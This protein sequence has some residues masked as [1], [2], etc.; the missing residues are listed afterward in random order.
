MLTQNP[1]SNGSKSSQGKIM[2]RWFVALSTLPLL[3][4]VT[5]FGLVPQGDFDLTST[6]MENIEEI[7]LPDVHIG[8][9]PDASYWHD[10]RLQRG[11]TVDELL[12]RLSIDDPAATICANLPTPIRSANCQSA[13]KCRRKPLPPA[14]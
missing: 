11:D 1:F 12:R 14:V 5:A 2:L 3:G 10:E 9:S 6:M 13:L 4:V 8:E 7:A